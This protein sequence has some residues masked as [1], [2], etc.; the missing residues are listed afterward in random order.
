MKKILIYSSLFFLF[1]ACGSNSTTNEENNSDSII[2]QEDANLNETNIS[3][4]E[5]EEAEE[6]LEV[7]TE[8]RDCSPSELD[9]SLND[10]DDSGTNIRKSPGGEVV[11]KLKVTDD[12][13]GFI[14]TLT[15][16]QNGWFKIKSPIDGIENEIKIPN[17]E[18][19]IHGSVVSVGTRNYGG[20]E[21]EL[22]DQPIN[23]KVVGVIK[24]EAYGLRIKDICG[25]W[26]KVEYKGVT[27]WIENEWL[28]GNPVTSC[29]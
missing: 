28:C 18:G 27:G 22:L 9:V 2:S 1:S 17:G 25:K 14:L 10:P 16:A 11:L 24:E 5:E 8:V 19:W 26:T 7:P 12:N 23:G 13:P 20:Q 21:L 15:E 29:S 3:E 4:N 6:V